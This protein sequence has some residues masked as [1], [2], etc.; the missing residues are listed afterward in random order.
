MATDPLAGQVIE[1]PA[2]LVAAMA[3]ELDPR[4]AARQSS[5]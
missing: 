4:A 3:A 5:R 1:M 2:A